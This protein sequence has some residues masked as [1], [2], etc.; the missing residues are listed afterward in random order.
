MLIRKHFGV[1]ACV[2]LFFVRYLNILLFS[3]LDV[4]GFLRGRE[5]QGSLS[6]AL[7]FLSRHLSKNGINI[8]AMPTS[9]LPSYGR[10]GRSKSERAQ[11]ILFS[12]RV[13]Q[14]IYAWPHLHMSAITMKK[15]QRK[16]TAADEA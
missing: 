16:R 10:G 8:V 11:H 1:C 13:L 12:Y 7:F 6:L 9:T 2:L 14:N 5:K 3:A 15:K 4:V